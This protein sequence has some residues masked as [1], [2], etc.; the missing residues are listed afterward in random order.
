MTAVEITRHRR[1]LA[2]AEGAQFVEAAPWSAQAS[3]Y[4]AVMRSMRE[5]PELWWSATSDPKVRAKR[6][7]ESIRRCKLINDQKRRTN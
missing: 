2:R 6:I 3:Y 5:E 1:L 7:D 4:F